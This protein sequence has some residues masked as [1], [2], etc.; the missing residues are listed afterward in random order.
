MT[1]ARTP[2]LLTATFAVTAMLASAIGAAAEV[3][4]EFVI[5]KQRF[6]L[7]AA[8]NDFIIRVVGRLQWIPG[9][10]A[11][12]GQIWQDVVVSTQSGTLAPEKADGSNKYGFCPRLYDQG[13]W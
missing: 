2:C 13:H 10:R 9:T 1:L 8:G 4:L 12:C 3:P 7:W 5:G 11:E 6:E